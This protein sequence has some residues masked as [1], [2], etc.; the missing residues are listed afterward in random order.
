[1][2]KNDIVYIEY[3]V[4]VKESGKLVETTHEETAKKEKIYN[5]KQKYKT[6]PVV[7]GTDRVIKGFD[8][9]LL[10][11]EIGKEYDIEIPASEA[12]GERDPKLVE[13]FSMHEFRRRKIT[14]E[15]GAEVNLK[16]K[17]GIITSVTAGRVRVDFNK[18]F[19]GRTLR[20]KYKIVKKVEE[21]EKVNAIIEMHYQNPE[22][23]DIK[24]NE[25]EVTIKLPDECKYD[26]VW[27][28]SKYSI[29]HDLR[30][31][32]EL[33]KIMFIEEYLK[34]EK[35]EKKEQEKTKGEAKTEGKDEKEKTKETKPEEEKTKTQEK[36]E[37]TETE[38]KEETN[39]K[40]EKKVMPL[41][42]EDIT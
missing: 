40:E 8:K 39:E 14:P 12:Y 26:Q 13:I 37:K 18:R 38:I 17:T 36:I 33:E 6:V 21:K 3:D 7:V 35:E 5:E 9:S 28:L 32:A 34:K 19:A 31:Y 24:L 20:Y 1:M 25:K 41:K 27:P 10:N 42:K 2:Q 23:F 15:I 4:W 29:V 16:N 22:S 11:A 30:E